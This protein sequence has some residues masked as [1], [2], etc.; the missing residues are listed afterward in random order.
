MT[1]NLAPFYL[2]S[3]YLRL[4]VIFHAIVSETLI[5][6][7][8]IILVTTLYYNSFLPSTLR[9]RHEV[10]G[11]AKQ[12]D[13][14]NAFK[15]FLNKDKSHILKHFYVGK[16]KKTQILHTR[17]RTNCSSLNLDLFMRN[18][19]DSPLCQ[20]GSAFLLSLQKLTCPTNRTLKYS[21]LVS[22]TIVISHFIWQ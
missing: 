10:P 9:A 2:S 15:R 14:V 17:L 6:L 5:I 13:S 7:K 18:I 21:I 12:S 11:K 19:S 20:C 4:S 22:D 8:K 16:R 1:H 3:L